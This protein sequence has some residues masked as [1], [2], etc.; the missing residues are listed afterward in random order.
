M[1]IESL[2]IKLR[3]MKFFAYH[4]VFPKEREK[5]G[6]YTVTL[7]LQLSSHK[8]A[9]SDVLADTVNY[10]DVY[11][12]VKQVMLTPSNLI[13]HVAARIAQAI[14]EEFPL[15]SGVTVKLTKDNPP[16][17]GANLKGGAVELKAKR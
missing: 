17:I 7:E 2:C 3:K 5:G 4:G 12:V 8:A 10:A 16:I 15:V 6:T 11:S 14:F 1:N 13:E 9:E